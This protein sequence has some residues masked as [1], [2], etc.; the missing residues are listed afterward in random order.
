MKFCMPHWEALRKAIDDRGL[1]SLVA[2][3]GTEVVSK[4]VG[5][6]SDGVSVDSFDPLMGAHNAP[7]PDGTDRCPLCFLNQD[8]VAHC[9]DPTCELGAT[10]FDAWIDRA[11]DEQLN[12]WKGLKL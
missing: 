12:V 6:S 1:Y 8:H 3:S 7:N 4:M 10:G 11:A 2:T 9:E 5:E